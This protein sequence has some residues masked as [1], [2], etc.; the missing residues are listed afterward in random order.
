MDNMLLGALAFV[1][2]VPSL[3]AVGIMFK[4]LLD[5]LDISIE[6]FIIYM[7][8]ISG[9]VVGSAIP[10]LYMMGILVVR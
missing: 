8:L 4:K 2:G 3:C 1:F 9:I 5:D 7:L 6:A 10:I